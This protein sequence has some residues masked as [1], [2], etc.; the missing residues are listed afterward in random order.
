[1]PTI[2]KFELIIPPELVK[3]KKT[4]DLLGVT[5]DTLAIWRCTQR[6]D[7]PYVRVGKSIM[8]DL[9]DVVNFIER[10]KIR[11]RTPK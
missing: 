9:K 6:Y 3:P 11:Q 4:A 5:E 2:D 8:Y 1:M 7:L 10:R